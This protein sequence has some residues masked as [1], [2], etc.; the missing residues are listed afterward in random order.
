MLKWSM[1]VLLK[2]FC[3]CSP[4]VNLSIKTCTCKVKNGTGASKTKREEAI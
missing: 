1:N 3:L 2:H 4:K